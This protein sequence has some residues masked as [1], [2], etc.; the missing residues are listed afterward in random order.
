MLS[1]IRA[2]LHKGQPGPMFNID[3][4]DDYYTCDDEATR[5][6]PVG[7]WCIGFWYLIPENTG[8]FYKYIFSTGNL[9][10]SSS[11]NLFIGE[12]GVGDTPRKWRCRGYD[13][14]TTTWDLTSGTT[15]EDDGVDRLLILQ[16]NETGGNFEL[17]LCPRNGEATLEDTVASAAYLASYRASQDLFLGARADLNADRLYGGGIGE[18]FKGNF[19][20]SGEEIEKLARGRTIDS[21]RKPGLE[22]YWPMRFPSLSQTNLINDAAPLVASPTLQGTN[23]TNRVI[24]P[25]SQGLLLAARAPETVAPEPELPANVVVTDTTTSSVSIPAFNDAVGTAYYDNGTDKSAIAWNENG[26]SVVKNG[27]VTER[28]RTYDSGEWTLEVPLPTQDTP[29]NTY[30]VS[31]ATGNDGTAAANDD[32]KPYRTIGALNAITLQPGDRVLFAAGETWSNTNGAFDEVFTPSGD[33][34][35]SN[36]IEIGQWGAGDRPIFDIEAAHIYAM[37]VDLTGAGGDNAS[38]MWINNI[39]FNGGIAGGLNCSIRIG[40]NASNIF[41]SD[42]IFDG[43]PGRGVF[44]SGTNLTFLHN[45]FINHPGNALTDG[46]SVDAAST[47]NVFAYNTFDNNVTAGGGQVTVDGIRKDAKFFGNIVK[48]HL[49]PN[50]A[51]YGEHNVAI[52][53]QHQGLYRIHHN[54]LDLQGSS[55]FPALAIAA[56]GGGGEVSH[57]IVYGSAGAVLPDA[58]DMGCAICFHL[59]RAMPD[60]D[61]TVAPL[62]KGYAFNNLI[63]GVNGTPADAN[64]RGAISVDRYALFDTGAHGEVWIWNNTIVD[65]INGINWQSLY[66]DN[67]TQNALEVN[68]N[69]ISSISGH[70]Q[71]YVED[72]TGH[73]K[74]GLRWVVNNNYYH[75]HPADGWLVSNEDVVNSGIPAEAMNFA[76]WTSGITTYEDDDANPLLVFDDNSVAAAASPQFTSTASATLSE[77]NYDTAS[78][79]PCRT[80][81]F[82]AGLSSLACKDLELFATRPASWIGLNNCPAPSSPNMGAYQHL[83]GEDLDLNNGFLGLTGEATSIII[84]S[85]ADD[86]ADLVTWTT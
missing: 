21:L 27:V 83:S 76:E 50:H 32:T 43:H 31:E 22:G 40:N 20:L 79:S 18:F 4:V 58:D 82:P 57:N 46:R 9:A 13:S 45:Q 54:I 36:W 6:F 34:T 28:W 15:I 56:K 72:A 85:I 37:T 23:Y 71:Q 10:S 48:R 24:M 68:N 26:Y 80:K 7:D 47:G 33:G 29:N 25:Y 44:T 1:Y 35:A 49:G 65:A 17:W 19:V 69:L 3:E 62:L 30:Y 66:M 59:A 12:E 63:V 75:D 86:E 55:A 51:V 42:C 2:L 81:N 61:P 53:A 41:V 73:F 5:T 52:E 38:Y 77:N 8:N 14:N 16:R 78:A 84:K 11:I 64:Y 67:E 70:C 74:P 60:G 39:E